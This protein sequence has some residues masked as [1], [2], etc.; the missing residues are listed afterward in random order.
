[1]QNIQRL[2]F[3]EV[4]G[5]FQQFNCIMKVAI[6]AIISAKIFYK[7]NFFI[8]QFMSFNFTFIILYFFFIIQDIYGGHF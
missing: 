1:M 8:P 3:N 7:Y 6:K 4:F 2:N 5:N